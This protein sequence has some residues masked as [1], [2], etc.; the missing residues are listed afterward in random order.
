MALGCCAAAAAPTG[1]AGFPPE[2]PS[3]SMAIA[4]DALCPAPRGLPLG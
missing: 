1:G 3:L 4:A 2:W